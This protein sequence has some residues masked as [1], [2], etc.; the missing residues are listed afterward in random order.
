VIRAEVRVIERSG[1]EKVRIDFFA[2]DGG[3]LATHGCLCEKG[4]GGAFADQAC[5]ALETLGIEHER[6]SAVTA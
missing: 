6:V 2:S 5:A 4:A 3:I 1:D